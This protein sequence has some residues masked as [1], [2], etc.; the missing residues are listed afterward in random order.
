MLFPP[1]YKMQNN[2][3]HPLIFKTRAVFSAWVFVHD[4][5]SPRVGAEQIVC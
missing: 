5:K 1:L 2:N 4:G 3:L